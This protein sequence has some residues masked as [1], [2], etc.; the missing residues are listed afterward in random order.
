MSAISDFLIW[1]EERYPMAH[2]E[3]PIDT[4]YCEEFLEE[5]EAAKL[6]AFFKEEEE[7]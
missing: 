7:Q 6:A 4:K 5:R 3:Q 2:A 1:L